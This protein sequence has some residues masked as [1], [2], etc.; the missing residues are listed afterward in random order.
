MTAKDFLRSRGFFNTKGIVNMHDQWH[1]IA[2]MLEEYAELQ[3]KE[4]AEQ[5]KETEN[6]LDGTT[7][8]HKKLVGKY[9]DLSRRFK[10]LEEENARYRRAMKK[11]SDFAFYTSEPVYEIVDILEESIN[12]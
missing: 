2:E 8:S 5:L 4:L 3:N 9:D 10:E 1:D 7:H 11:A 12:E 6:L